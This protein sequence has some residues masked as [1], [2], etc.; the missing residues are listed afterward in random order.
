MVEDSTRPVRRT[1]KSLVEIT[2]RITDLSPTLK[3]ALNFDEIKNNVVKHFDFKPGDV[4]NYLLG[5]KDILFSKL[6]VVDPEKFKLAQKKSDLSEFTHQ[7]LE[8]SVPG[9]VEGGDFKNSFTYH[10]FGE[11]PAFNMDIEIRGS[12]IKNLYLTDGHHTMKADYDYM[13]GELR[14]L[15]TGRLG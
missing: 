13:E 1:S 10:N 2:E 6:K 11:A 3:K 7:E 14:K 8:H 9:D 5:N 12:Y 4:V 15:V